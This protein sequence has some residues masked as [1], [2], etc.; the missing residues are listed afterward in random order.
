MPAK[1]SGES[2]LRSAAKGLTWRLIATGTIILLAW[3]KTGDVGFALELGAVEF[4]IK[5]ALY[6]LHERAWAAVPNVLAGKRDDTTSAAETAT[7]ATTPGR[8]SETTT[9]P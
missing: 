7:T 9:T 4:I 2:H 5:F 8:P 1:A 6:Y 3:W